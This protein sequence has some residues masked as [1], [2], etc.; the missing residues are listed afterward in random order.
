MFFWNIMSRRLHAFFLNE[1]GTCKTLTSAEHHRKTMVMFSW[2]LYVNNVS[3]VWSVKFT[4]T[5]LNVYGRNIS[6][7]YD[8]RSY[9]ING[10]MH[11]NTY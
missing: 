1:A 7:I 2:E 10:K 3:N 8:R 4:L 11:V 9:G 6:I 5:D